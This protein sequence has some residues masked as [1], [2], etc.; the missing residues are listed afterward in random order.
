MKEC[1]CQAEG[2]I[3]LVDGETGNWIK[4]KRDMHPGILFA[5]CCFF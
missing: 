3:F 5:L 1:I 4:I 2:A